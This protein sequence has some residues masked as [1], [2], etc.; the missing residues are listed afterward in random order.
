MPEEEEE[1]EV[2]TTG[3]NFIIKNLP[4]V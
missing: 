4:S 3:P 2:K 1:E